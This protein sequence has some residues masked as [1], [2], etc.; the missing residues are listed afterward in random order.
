MIILPIKCNGVN[1]QN[2][3]LKIYTFEKAKKIKNKN[4]KANFNSVNGSKFVFYR[5]CKYKQDDFAVDK[6]SKI[7]K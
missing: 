1:S 4:Y 5:R 7:K 6:R 3:E 2:V